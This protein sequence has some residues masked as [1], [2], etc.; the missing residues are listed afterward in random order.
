MREVMIVAGA[1]ALAH[2]VA[3]A[4]GL[5]HAAPIEFRQQGLCRRLGVAMH[6][7]LH[8][9]LIAE[10]RHLDVDLRHHRARRD[11]LA[12]LGGPLREAR[13]EPENEIAFRD[14]LVGDR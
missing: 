6:G 7:K 9:H 1:D 14:Q 12:L 8:R 5:A 10:L 2:R 3:A 4:A 13:A 11:Q